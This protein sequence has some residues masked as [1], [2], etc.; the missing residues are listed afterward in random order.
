[1][2]K[3]LI[4]FFIFMILPIYTLAQ[5]TE[6][7]SADSILDHP[8]QID[9]SG[10][11]LAWY[12]P[13]IPG[14]GYIE[15]VKRSSEFVKNAPVYE[16][17]GLKMYFISCCFKGPHMTENGEFVAERW[18]HNPACIWAGLVQGLV[19]DYRV[20]SGDV[21]FID[22]LRE[23]LDYQLSHGT[24]PS[25]WRWASV[26][27]ASADPF[28]IDYQGAGKWERDGM[29][30]DGLHGIEPD[31]LGELG[32]A[33]L[34]FYQ[35]TEEK[36]FL[37]AAI[38]CANA[39]AKHV[40]DVRPEKKNFV[41]AETDRSP[42]PFRVNARTGVVI[43]DYCSNVI[44]PIRLFDELRRIK[45]R[46]NL[47]IKQDSSYQEAR[48]IAWEWLY[49][50]NG[51]MKTSIWNAYFE[52]IPN[53][54]EKTNRVQITPMETARYLIKNPELDPNIETTV[55][56]LIHWVANAF[57]TEGW[58]AIKEQTWCYL[59]M[60][61]HTSRFASICAL[62][63]EQT[64]DEW[65]KEQAE[66]YFNYATYMCMENGVVAVGANWPGSWWSDG[67]G[68]YIRH[69]TEGIAAIPEWSIS[70]EN[71]LLK[72]TS[73]IQSINYE[74]NKINYQTYDNAST[75]V[76]RL[77][78]KPKTIKVSDQVLNESQNPD[79]TGWTWRSLDV[80][81]V[82][83]LKHDQGNQVEIVL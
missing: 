33:Y 71:H 51:P 83:K 5:L 52:D 21:S 75:E 77:F 3:R 67:Y 25:E 70:G 9:S 29:R 30:G 35:V 2:R 61:S 4:L 39:L 48:D 42:W 32:I 82:L 49:S 24:T 55:P 8:L 74:K 26:P 54:P 11:L 73:V 53:D 66:R 41:L 23:M 28:E 69:F 17:L 72:S 63:Y 50:I 15:V 34:K 14:A 44:E 12:Q 19:L 57:A 80:G 37:E 58:D 43:S 59:P 81:G 68:D 13:Q 31:K 20:Y 47:T 64:G 22:L 10:K 36:R 7:V 38:H 56:A 65:Y 79:P 40:R 45:D 78:S 6:N 16:P 60:G 76:F 62:W 1:M 18:M 27:Y 46:I